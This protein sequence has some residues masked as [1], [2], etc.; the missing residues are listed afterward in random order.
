MYYYSHQGKTLITFLNRLYFFCRIVGVG[1]AVL[2]EKTN[3]LLIIKERVRNR[4]F[5]KVREVTIIDDHNLCCSLF[6]YL[7]VSFLIFYI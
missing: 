2:R 1:G 5:W 4:E 7:V 3:E 6:S